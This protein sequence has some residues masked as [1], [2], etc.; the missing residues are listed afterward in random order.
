MT[1]KNA[2]TKAAKS[3]PPKKRG[4]LR[5]AYE[6][7][8]KEFEAMTCGIEDLN[9]VEPQFRQAFKKFLRDCDFHLAEKN[10]DALLFEKSGKH[11]HRS[12]RTVSWYHEVLPIIWD[13]S[14]VLK[15]ASAQGVDIVEYIP[16]GGLE[17]D[18]VSHL[19][20]DSV[21]DFI[22]METLAAQ[23]YQ[24]LDEMI[25]QDC[26][27]YI[28]NGPKMVEQVLINVRLM[29]QRP[30]NDANGG[31]AMKNGKALK[32]DVIEYTHRMVDDPHANPIVFKKKQLDVL[33]NFATMLGAEK[34]TPE[35]RAKR[36]NERENMYGARFGFTEI[37]IAKWKP[38]S[39]VIQIFDSNMGE[40]LYKNFRYLENVDEFYLNSEDAFRRKAYDYPVSSRFLTRALTLNVPEIIH[41]L[42]MFLKRMAKSADPV[43]DPEKYARLQSFMEKVIKP[44]LERHRD[45]FPY[46]FEESVAPAQ[47]LSLQQQPQP[48]PLP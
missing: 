1:P 17:A 8:M 39:R 18:I 2:F 14:T 4:E 45:H 30:Q 6:R 13:L 23:Q 42:H 16:Y 48:T 26:S 12:D 33:H 40:L 46:I 10:F 34:F 24:M 29:T 5:L 35:R 9:E 7:L 44:S 22:T 36:C 19:R 15:G 3:T 11:F 47:P 28:E 38:F 20:H 32:E 37:A 31:I 21:E 25:A 41:P 43:A 27:A